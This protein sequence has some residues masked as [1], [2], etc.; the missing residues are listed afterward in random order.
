[1]HWV[2]EV[3]PIEET[4]LPGDAGAQGPLPDL[5]NVPGAHDVVKPVNVTGAAPGGMTT[6]SRLV[7]SRIASIENSLSKLPPFN[8]IVAPAGDAV[9]DR[10]VTNPD[11]GD[12][13]D[14]VYCRRNVS[15]LVVG[16]VETQRSLNDSRAMPLRDCV[17]MLPVDG[18]GTDEPVGSDDDDEVSETFGVAT[19]ELSGLELADA[20][21]NDAGVEMDTGVEI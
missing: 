9:L 10:T 7:E 12:V 6:T 1:M 21:V 16:S 5:L 20:G 2:C 19:V 18:T 11:A 4:K 13:G 3:A 15:R 8:S 17:T 14:S